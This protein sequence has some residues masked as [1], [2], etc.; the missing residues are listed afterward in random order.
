MM[1]TPPTP[2]LT[3]SAV[4]A[5]AQLGL[6]WKPVLAWPWGVTH[7][8]DPSTNQVVRHVEAWDV[9]ADVGVGML[10]RPGPPGGLDQG[11]T[12]TRER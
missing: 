4:H 11:R 1:P 9:S 7:V 3:T 2:L 12:G 5:A 8:F 10:L 6:P